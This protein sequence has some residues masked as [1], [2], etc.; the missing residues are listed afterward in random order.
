[1]SSTTFSTDFKPAVLES[2]DEGLPDCHD[3]VL[4]QRVIISKELKIGVEEQD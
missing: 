3:R 2:A 4:P 1:M